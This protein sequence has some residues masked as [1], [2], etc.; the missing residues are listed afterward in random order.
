LLKVACK[1]PAVRFKPQTDTSPTL[2]GCVGSLFTYY[3]S[4]TTDLGK[5]E[6]MPSGL[7][8]EETLAA[9]V[10]CRCWTCERNTGTLDNASSASGFCTKIPASKFAEQ[11]AGKRTM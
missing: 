2:Y 9:V 1:C 7:T 6:D 5:G 10:G 11:R 4:K 3:F 8:M